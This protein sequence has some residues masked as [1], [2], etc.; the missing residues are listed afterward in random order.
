MFSFLYAAKDY[1]CWHHL[2][3]LSVRSSH[4]P[5][6]VH[7]FLVNPTPP[8]FLDGFFL[9]TCH[10]ACCQGI[11]IHTCIMVKGSFMLYIIFHQYLI[12][13]WSYLDEIFTDPVTRY[14][15][16]G[17]GVYCCVLEKRG[18]M[19]NLN[20]VYTYHHFFSTKLLPHFMTDLDKVFTE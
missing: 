17:F 6:Y 20:C 7:P 16:S 11:V 5:P 9:I 1:I 18:F 19:S 10:S 2:L 14:M 15:L 3:P 12:Y 13:H 8:T 4:R